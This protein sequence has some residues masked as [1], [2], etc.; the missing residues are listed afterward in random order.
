MNQAQL[1]SV[2]VEITVENI[3]ELVFGSD[4]PVLLDFW[5]SWCVPCKLMRRSVE[6]AAESLGGDVRVGLVNIDQQPDIVSNFG[7]Q[8]T[9]TF[10]L[11]YKGQVEQTFAGVSTAGGLVNRVRQALFQATVSS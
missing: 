3:E 7:V 2:P 1:S 10:V 9:P 5:A 4:V 11:L 8:G 6:K